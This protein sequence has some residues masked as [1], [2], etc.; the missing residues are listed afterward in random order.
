[1]DDEYGRVEYGGLPVPSLLDNRE[2]SGRVASIQLGRRMTGARLFDVQPF[3]GV[4]C[5]QAGPH[6][7]ADVVAI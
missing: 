3:F 6:E 5:V 4:H 7:G 1:L 2:V